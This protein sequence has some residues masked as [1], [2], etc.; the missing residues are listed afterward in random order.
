MNFALLSALLAISCMR[1]SLW[2]AIDA[3]VVAANL[4]PR[5]TG[6]HA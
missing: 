4:A 1:K 2:Q 3:W 5:I 6:L